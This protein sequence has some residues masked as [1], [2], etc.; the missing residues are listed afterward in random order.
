MKPAIGLVFAF[1]LF[2]GSHS[3]AADVTATDG[4]RLSFTDKGRV[5][6]L[7]LGDLQLPLLAP[8]GFS[9]IDY[10]DQPQPQNIVANPGLE[11]GLQGWNLLAGQE[12]D[13]T[14]AHTGAASVRISIPGPKPAS[15]SV[16]RTIDVKP[17]TRYRVGLWMRRHNCGVCGA[18]VSEL[19]GDGK[20][21][22]PVTQ[23]GF[24][25][26]R[27]DD[28][29]A[30]AGREIETGPRTAKLLLRGDIYRSTGTVWLDD[31]T[32]CEIRPPVAL[33]VEGAL[34]TEG[35]AARLEAAVAALELQAVF[36]ASGPCVRVDGEL[37]D[38][39]GRDRAVALR[40]DLPF[41]AK[42]WTWFTDI[43]ERAVVEAPM[44]YAY[45]YPCES[46]EGV[47]SVYPWS[48]L[49]GSRAGLSIALPVSQGPRVFVV[50]YD[51]VRRAYSLTFFFGLSG[52]AK[53][54]PGRAP[55]SFVL[56]RHD[57]A[58]GM[59]SATARYYEMFPESFVKRS[60]F[61]AYLNYA[62]LERFDPKTHK[63]YFGGVSVED[64]SDFG[65]GLKFLWHL[66]GCYDFRMMP[67]PDEKLP[68]DD[69]VMAFLQKL[70]GNEVGSGRYYCPTGETIKKIVHDS[71]GRIRYIGDTQYW[72][73]HEGYNHTDKPGWGL[74]FRVNEDPDISPI[75]ANKSREVV[76]KYSEQPGRRPWDACLTADAIEGYHGNT[77]GLD[78]RPEHIAVADSPLTFGRESLKPAIPNTIWDFHNTVW[79]PL[80]QRHKVLTYGNANGYEQIFTMPF[81]DIPMIEWDWDV[82]H[83][84]RF[85]R[86][87]RMTAYQKIWRFWRVCGKGEKDRD[88]VIAHFHR[89][90][91]GAVY[92]SVYGVQI[93]GGSLE[94]YRA[95]YRRYVP[96][97]EA[98]SSAGWEPIPYA[99]TGCART[100]DPDVVV[101]RYGTL[102]QGTL[103]LTFRNYAS[104]PKS[105][106]VSLDLDGLQYPRLGQ[107]RLLACDLLEGPGVLEM[108][109]EEDWRV[110]LPG[111]SARA[112]WLGTA[113]G[114][115][116]N[117][118]LLK[119]QGLARIE[120]FF[121]SE[122][123]DD[124][125][126]LIEEAKRM[127][128]S[129]DKLSGFSDEAERVMGLLDALEP[130]VS[131]GATVDRAKIFYRVRSEFSL[132][133]ARLGGL[134][135]QCPRTV[136]G[137]RG[138]AAVVAVKVANVGRGSLAGLSFS[139][140]SPW[141]EV[142]EQS[143][144]PGAP[145]A[146]DP[147][148]EAAVEARLAVPANP[149]RDLLP[150][151]IVCKGRSEGKAFTACLPV[152]VEV[153]APLALSVSPSRVFR[154]ESCAATVAVRNSLPQPVRGVLRLGPHPKLK[155]DPAEFPF[156]APA[157]SDAA[158][159]TSD[160]R[161]KVSLQ[162]LPDAHLGDMY[163][164]FEV[165]SDDA[166]LNMRGTLPVWVGVPVPR[167]SIRRLQ[168]APVVDGD[169]G[170]AAWQSPPTIP[171]FRSLRAGGPV[172]EKTAVWVAYDDAGI[173]VAFRC[174][175]SDLPAL[176]AEMTERG[177]PLYNEDDVEFFLLP[178]GKTAALQFA[179]NPLGTQ[180]DN[181]G[182]S[183]PWKAAA[184]KTDAGWTVEAFMPYACLG[185]QS[186]AQPGD[187]WSA[188]FGRQQKAKFETSAWTIS[189]AFNVPENFGVLRFE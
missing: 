33:P 81:C 185:V 79:W 135:I 124:N 96:A 118:C 45:T 93:Q 127:A 122:L 131:T 189:P 29:W 53:K 123:S 129:A 70:T 117:A 163:L 184:R 52:H 68:P 57:P 154:G 111:N 176:K 78:Y 172:S 82:Q 86:N 26:P 168:K 182:D 69:E 56:Y 48:A 36:S 67:T 43:E 143:H 181:F 125:R 146:L 84:G 155:P 139:V 44:R 151:L 15:S 137:Y 105:L 102:R 178:A 73:P 4:L 138:A 37:R 38:V 30:F 173:Y 153:K 116:A 17:N 103:H 95:H 20:L 156:E 166:R 77:R 11:E 22:G 27:Q 75:L 66:H 106:K 101:E 71:E 12:I 100:G 87:L 8:G 88:S 147:G 109:V 170:D 180:S 188:Q 114:L 64:A 169:L 130:A 85:E 19:D 140:M 50:E 61:E 46:G 49:T 21:C 133:A 158:R 6:S 16:N 108:G 126:R 160:A 62:N 120:R 174:A 94:P 25:V 65:E 167:A 63:L 98:L 51:N 187:E 92:P 177:S 149:E 113:S 97:I 47:C 175:E 112:F 159:R 132:A 60:S 32:V 40:F 24:A 39:S 179:V 83:P 104:A 28:V 34:K 107:Q 161:A 162:V 9:V 134:R 115:A 58:W 18:Y 14:T 74:N 59:R 13:K 89:C 157:S 186:P 10:Q 35:G 119:D 148:R 171:E 23:I 128:F 55:F 142:C 31:F 183:A 164:P 144:C 76:E 5:A 41:D 2:C 80:T 54:Q 91:A 1:A 72:K 165:K 152:D 136:E 145:A 7:R 110:E 42:G 150:F 99:R 3:R 121:S 141:K 90:L